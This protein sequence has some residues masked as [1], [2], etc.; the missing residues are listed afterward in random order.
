MVTEEICFPFYFVSTLQPLRIQ[1]TMLNL[2]AYQPGI[3]G[4]IGPIP[5]PFLEPQKEIV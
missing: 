2:L 5:P 1:H 3:E 4:T